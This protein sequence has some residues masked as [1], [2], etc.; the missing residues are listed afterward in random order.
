M[1]SLR[2]TLDRRPV[3]VSDGLATE[4][5]ALEGRVTFLPAG[6]VEVT[7]NEDTAEGKVVF[8]VP[9]KTRT[10]HVERLTLELNGGRVIKFAARKGER[11]FRTFLKE[12]TGDV[13]RFGFFGLG[14][15][16]RLKFGYTQ[17]DKVL[18]GVTVGLGDNKSKGGRNRAGAEWWGC[19]TG[20]TVKIGRRTIIV[21]GKLLP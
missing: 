21:R 16:P 1:A 2:F 9:N 20:G 19:M 4:A 8:D 10:G 15:N 12:G 6:A 18:G 13:D 14:L 11:L 3:Q 17:D 7:A 5:K